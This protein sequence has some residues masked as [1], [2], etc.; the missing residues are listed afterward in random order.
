MDRFSNELR[1][2]YEDYLYPDG[3]IYYNEAGDF[4][5]DLSHYM[6]KII[7]KLLIEKIIMKKHL[8]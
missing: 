2:I 6:T 4:S 7:K 5:S 8:N 3:F 1:H